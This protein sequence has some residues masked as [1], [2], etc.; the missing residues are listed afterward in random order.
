[1]SEPN[2][3]L[4]S[5]VNDTRSSLDRI[6]DKI[7]NTLHLSDYDIG[8]IRDVNRTLK[9]PTP[10][11]QLSIQSR[12][13]KLDAMR[14]DLLDLIFDVGVQSSDLE[15]KYKERYDEAFAKLVRADRPSQQAIDSEIHAMDP[16]MRDM[17]TTL[18]NY[19]LLRGLLFG[20]LKSLDKSRETCMKL[21]GTY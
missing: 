12:V 18:N 3:I 14:V 1:M 16:A 6:L 2:F 7:K 5:A 8:V 11:V 17:R 20:Y 21:W 4:A 15:Y 13:S 19:E 9:E 10:S